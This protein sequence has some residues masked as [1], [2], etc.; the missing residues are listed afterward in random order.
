MFNNQFQ[1]IPTTTANNPND[2]NFLSQSPQPNFN[3]FQHTTQPRDPNA[4]GQAKKRHSDLEEVLKNYKKKKPTDRSLPSNL[5]SIESVKSHSKMY[6]DLIRFEKRL[7]MLSAHKRSQIQDSL[8]RPLK[9][10]RKLRIFISNSASFQPW[11]QQNVPQPELN[12]ESGLG[13]PSWNL[14]IEGRLLDVCVSTTSSFI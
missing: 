7:D 12:F 3:Q 9:S 14:K 10:T 2:L 1:S 13:I 11:Q 6:D 4:L 5:N 8:Q